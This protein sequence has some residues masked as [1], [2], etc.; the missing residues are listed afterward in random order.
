MGFAIAGVFYGGLAAWRQQDFKRLIA[1]SSLAHVNFILAGLFVWN[2]A[3]ISGAILQALNHAITITALFVA[4]G[5]LEERLGSTKMETSGL[6]NLC[7]IFAGS[8][9]FLSCPRSRCQAQTIS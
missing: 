1:Y 5:W 3:A 9:S 7:P 2:E 6:L 4:S 8:H